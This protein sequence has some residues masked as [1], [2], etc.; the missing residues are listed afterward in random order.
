[1][2]WW[3]Y[4]QLDRRFPDAAVASLQHGSHGTTG[5]FA[6]PL[7]IAYIPPGEEAN[8]MKAR[9]VVGPRGDFFLKLTLRRFLQHCSHEIAGL[10]SLLPDNNGRFHSDRSSQG[11]E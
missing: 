7:P 8:I 5:S 1:M 2:W 6:P 9:A 4:P 3:Y 10:P 11:W